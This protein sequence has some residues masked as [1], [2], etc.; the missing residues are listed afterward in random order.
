MSDRPLTNHMGLPNEPGYSN[1]ADVTPRREGGD[2]SL[3]EANPS[4]PRNDEKV[5]TRSESERTPAPGDAGANSAP[6]SN[7][8][9][10]SSR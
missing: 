2:D 9:S 1:P 7:E 5:L 4:D 10:D 8:D 6:R 3:A